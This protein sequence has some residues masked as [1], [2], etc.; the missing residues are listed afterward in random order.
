MFFVA[1]SIAVIG[2]LVL[3][4]ALWRYA[5]DDQPFIGVEEQRRATEALGQAAEAQRRSAIATSQASD[6]TIRF[7]EPV[8]LYN[9]QDK[10]ECEFS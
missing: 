10:E 8:K 3:S 1:V 5:T 2:L 6:S 9:W 7:C 4:Y